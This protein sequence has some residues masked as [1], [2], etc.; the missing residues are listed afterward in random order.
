MRAR[1]QKGPK[2]PGSQEPI[3]GAHFELFFL[4]ISFYSIC[5]TLR[6]MAKVS[7]PPGHPNC[8]PALFQGLLNA[9][10]LLSLKMRSKHFNLGKVL[11]NSIIHIKDRYKLHLCK[12]TGSYYGHL[13]CYVFF[14]HC[15]NSASVCTKIF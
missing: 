8:G 6:H 14:F 11:Y 13:C 3:R 7:F 10:S 9:S 5:R 15:M 4:F 2:K 12:R 1:Q